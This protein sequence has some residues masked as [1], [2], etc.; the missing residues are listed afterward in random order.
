MIIKNFNYKCVNSTNDIAINL[1]KKKNIRAGLVLAEKQ[2]KG[3]GQ[4]G[5]KWISYKGNLFVSIF[6]SLDKINLTLKQLT[7]FNANL[8]IRLI[9]QYY[10]KKIK[11][12]SPND[13]LVNKKKI[14]GILQETIMNNDKKFIII[15]IGINLIRSPKIK[16]YPTT[17]IYKETGKKINKSNLLKHIKFNYE[18]K[19]KRFALRG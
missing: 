4:R 1:I 5:K 17:N 6:F 14:C 10:K 7:K 9:S 15:G 18:K 3:R 13:I 12:K 19:F 2:K 11:L 16:N 8:V